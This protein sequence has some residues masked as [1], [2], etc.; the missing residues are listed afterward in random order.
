MEV[1]PAGYVDDNGRD[2]VVNRVMA[3]KHLEDLGDP[4]SKL[5]KHVETILK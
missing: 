4:L 2:F 3:L 5:K 1:S